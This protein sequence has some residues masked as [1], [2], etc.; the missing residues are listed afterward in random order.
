MKFLQKPLGGEEK[1]RMRSKNTCQGRKQY[2]EHFS[3]VCL[4]AGSMLSGM[5][6]DKTSAGSFILPGT[7]CL[8]NS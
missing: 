8:T 6:E 4:K 3:N 2:M 1:M 7:D 5:N